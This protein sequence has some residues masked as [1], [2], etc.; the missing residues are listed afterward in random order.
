MRFIIGTVAHCSASYLLSWTLGGYQ[1]S[2]PKS[3]GQ[4][5]QG[6]VEVRAQP[7]RLPHQFDGRE[8]GEQFFEEHLALQTGQMGARPLLRERQPE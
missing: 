6:V 8:L 2:A 3:E 4:F 1:L 7:L 5:L